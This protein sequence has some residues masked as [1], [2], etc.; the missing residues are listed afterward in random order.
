M[1]S[2][3]LVYFVFHI[4]L[5]EV[6]G[7]VLVLWSSKLVKVE[8]HK[9]QFETLNI[10]ELNLSLEDLILRNLDPQY[11]YSKELKILKK[12]SC[13]FPHSNLVFLS[14]FSIGREWGDW[15]DKFL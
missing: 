7:S 14:T 13:S 5:K 15:E 2:Q 4:V 12:A 8:N 6:Q 11:E 3:H 10:M 9:N 1:L